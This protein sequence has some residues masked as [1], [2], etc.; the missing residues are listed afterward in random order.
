MDFNEHTIENSKD[1]NT[2]YNV[3]KRERSEGYQVTTNPK[4]SQYN[5]FLIGTVITVIGLIIALSAPIDRHLEKR[6]VIKREKMEAK[7][8]LNQKISE[9]RIWDGKWKSYHKGDTT[10]VEIEMLPDGNLNAVS[11]TSKGD[12]LTEYQINKT[13]KKGNQLIVE[14]EVSS[15]NTVIEL[16]LDEP[17]NGVMV[18]NYHN[19]IFPIGVKH[20]G[21]FEFQKDLLADYRD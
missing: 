4:I 3:E 8:K 11:V 14:L 6:K 18:G 10:T 5:Q 1:H 7:N 16:F 13:Y 19:Q 21:S 20:Q 2:D 12:A 15:T 17:A 9:H